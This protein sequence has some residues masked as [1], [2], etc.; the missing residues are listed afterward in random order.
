MNHETTV[1]PPIVWSVA[2]SDSGA[3]AG[4][5]ADLRAFEAMDVHGC[6]VVAAI[7]AQNSMG[8]QL[9]SPVA[10]SVLN[11]QLAAL[12]DD[13]PPAAI[14]VGMIGSVENLHVL[15]QWIDRLRQTNPQLAV[16]VDPVFG[17]TTG[18]TFAQEALMQAYRDELL[19]RADVITPNRAEAAL[20][21]QLAS[22]AD[23]LAVEQAAQSLQA[24]GCQTVII[25]G[26]DAQGL[27]S[28]DYCLS[29][30][31][32]GWL[33]LPRVATEHNHGTGCVFASSAAA[34][35]AR[36][37]VSM[38]ALV[39][40]KMATTHALRHAYSAGQGAGPVRPRSDFG[41]HIE[42]LPSFSLPSASR[43]S[44]L[45][46]FEPLSDPN[47]GLYAVVDSADWV[48]RVLAAGVKTVQLRIKG[49]ELVDIRREVQSAIQHAKS[50]SA[51]LFIND[52][53]Q[54]AIEEGAYGVHLGQE[55][56]HIADLDAIAQ[57]GLR[58]GIST[59][60][61]WEVCRAWQLQPSYIAC[62]PIY[63]TRAKDMPW[64]AQGNHNL[65]YWSALL[66]LPVVA[67]GGITV[68]QATP[69]RRAG[70]AGV[71][72]ISAITA[73]ASPESA[74]IELQQALDAVDWHE[75]QGNKLKTHESAPKLP[76][77]TL[78]S[79]ESPCFVPYSSPK[80]TALP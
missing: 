22:L 57:A 21:L 75:L 73:A 78:Y 10:A 36:G 59:H 43:P 15:V 8:V 30:H 58:L 26:G 20:L 41:Q 13:M 55:D 61:Y 80:F 9:I 62:G 47:L 77:S 40:A 46:R 70:A 7:T 19:P 4:L 23:A 48:K 12:A 24:L 76:K 69:S 28:E 25:T 3:G 68:A 5:Q 6:T 33:R 67:I 74:I 66:P 65:T 52:H 2:G 31:A 42:N 79:S 29:P 35:M 27:N 32:R 37:F 18:A 56:L 50:A 44:R 16:V 51:Q 72:V 38:E 17:A 14:K 39:L 1:R 63:P 54:I 71:A 60:G 34:A 11:A 49:P 64:Q 53:W 45:T